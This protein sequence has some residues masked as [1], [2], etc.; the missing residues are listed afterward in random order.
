M[1]VRC[2]AP[3]RISFGGGGTDVDPYRSEHGGCALSTTID[4]YAYVS[5][6]ERGDESIEVQSLDYDIV[7]KYSSGDEFVLNGELDLARAVVGRLRP[8]GTHKGFDL[9]LQSDAP[10]GSGLGSS[11]TMVVALVTLFKDYFHRPMTA[12]EIAELAYDVERVEL[13]LKGGMQDQYAA[14]FGGFNYIEFLPD[15][16]IVNPLR[17][18]P[19]VLYELQYNL[20]LCYTGRTRRSAGIIDDQVQRFSQG[21]S[22][23]IEAAHALKDLCVA[24]KNAL[25]QGQ[26]NEFAALLDAGWQQKRKFAARIS[27]PEIDEMYEEAHKAG[28]LGGKLLGAGGGGYLLVYAPFT[29]RH[30]VA[31]RLEALGGQM[32]DFGFDTHG[33]VSWRA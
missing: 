32:V 33:A 18:D 4:K 24:M 16:V 26:L 2:K 29:K 11:S 17:L 14:T 3:L 6:Q 9:F 25:L 21:Q 31:E 10:P 20:L 1:I 19:A 15:K 27:N 28:A 12:Y 23:V 7:A 22:D 5:C 8:E 30:R 13:G